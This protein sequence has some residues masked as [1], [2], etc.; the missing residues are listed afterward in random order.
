M[1]PD[2]NVRFGPIDDY[3]VFF[4]PSHNSFDKIFTHEHEVCITNWLQEHDIAY[5]IQHSTRWALTIKIPC[6]D[7]RVMI[8]LTFKA[9]PL[10]HRMTVHKLRRLFTV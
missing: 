2:I 3:V 5:D 4:G 8:K 10:V 6:P 9:E 7:A 1:N